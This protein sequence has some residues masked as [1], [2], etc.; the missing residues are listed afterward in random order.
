M[1]EFL[2][3]IIELIQAYLVPWTTVYA[4]EQGVRFTLGKWWKTK[5]PGF[6]IYVPVLQKYDVYTVTYQE[7]DCL[8]QSLATSDGKRIIISCNVGYVVNDAGKMAT[9]VENF[10]GTLERAA[11]VHLFSVV[12]ALNYESLRGT[13]DAVQ[14]DVRKALN[15]QTREWG[16]KVRRVGI[17]DLQE[18]RPIRL[19]N[20][21]FTAV[22]PLG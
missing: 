8:T 1:G 4:D 17:T 9:R 20:D 19:H 10:D 14:K 2:R 6:H 15:E 13:I 5:G 12:Q 22:I 18:V 16:V 11:R 21:S 3:I 7:I